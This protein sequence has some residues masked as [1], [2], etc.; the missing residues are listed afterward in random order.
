MGISAQESVSVTARPS[1]RGR[2]ATRMV[3]VIVKHWA[4]GDPPAVV[5]RAR[6]VFGLPNFASLL[7]SRGIVI[8]QV[9]TGAAAG[10]AAKAGAEKPLAER[11]GADQ[12]GYYRIRGEW[13][14]PHG[15]SDSGN[16]IL[17][18]H[19][20]GYVSC[21]P[22]T[23][24]PITTSLAR[25]AR[26]RVF[27]LDY[28]LAPEHPFPAAVDDAAAAFRWLVANGVSANKIA[29]AGDSAG[30][31]LVLATMLRL[32]STG[33]ALP[34]CGVCLSPWVDLTGADQYQNSGSC[35]MFQPADVATFAVLYL[36]G[37]RAETA[38]ASPLFADLSG[39]PPLLTQV[40]STELLLDDAVRLH[41]KAER[42]GVASALSVY[43]GLPHVWQIFTPLIPEAKTAFA[44]IASFVGK[45]WE[46]A[47]GKAPEHRARAN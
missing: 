38:E 9:D 3:R 41:R 34:A 8:E 26:C 18:L 46:G 29:V 12:A 42:C 35:S 33:V 6:R 11:I 32:R 15:L 36:N 20:G 4:K 5:R 47:A 43:P 22:Q 2:I 19:G 7:Q 17:Y 25:M 30:G 13:V 21:T 10:E 39:L 24:R 45:A 40:S 16:V 44:E 31:G 28:R 27:S 23:H 14:R 1:L 37:A